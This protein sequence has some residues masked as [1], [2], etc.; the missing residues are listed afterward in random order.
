MRW[1]NIP[2]LTQNCGYEERRVSFHVFAVLPRE[3]WS[4][5]GR[6][7]SGDESFHIWISTSATSSLRP[8][9]K[10]DV[11]PEDL[12]V[13]LERRNIEAK[14]EKV[15]L[16]S[17]VEDLK[18][19]PSLKSFEWQLRRRHINYYVERSGSTLN[20]PFILN[21]LLPSR[22]RYRFVSKSNR[23]NRRGCNFAHNIFKGFK[24]SFL[25]RLAGDHG[26]LEKLRIRLERSK[27]LLWATSIALRL[28]CRY[29]HIVQTNVREIG[30]DSVGCACAAR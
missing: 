12:F 4:P 11:D 24:A 17:P 9:N 16:N 22:T 27:C 19:S 29:K 13:F 26:K 18:N 30:K 14:R 23:R 3:I 20:L 7:L 21:S 25:H 10:V 1:H 6:K 5:L 8:Q 2:G 15:A 28:V